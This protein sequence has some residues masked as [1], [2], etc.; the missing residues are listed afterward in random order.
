MNHRPQGLIISKA[1]TGFLQFKVAEGLSVRTTDSYRRILEQWLE[2]QK[3]VEV[4]SITTQQLRDYLNYM[5][6]DYVPKRITGNNDQKL[7]SKSIRNIYVGLSAFF[8]WAAEEFQIPNP[9]KSVPAPKFT[10]PEVEPFR[11]K[12]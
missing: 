6:T 1:V 10:S 11:R 12:K 2:R 5:R 9:M 4:S 3:D 8:H 7:S